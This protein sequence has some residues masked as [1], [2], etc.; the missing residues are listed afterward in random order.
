MSLR[1]RD[2]YKVEKW[3]MELCST[4]G[5]SPHQ[6]RAG[7]LFCER[8]RLNNRITELEDGIG[9]LESDRDDLQRQVADLEGDVRDL[10][11]ECDDL[12]NQV[13]NLGIERDQLED[14][15][16]SM[17]VD[18]DDNSYASQRVEEL[19]SELHQLEDELE[20]LRNER[21][22]EPAENDSPLAMEVSKLD[23]KLQSRQKQIERLR[24]QLGQRGQ[25]IDELETRLRAEQEHVKRLQ[26]H[27]AQLHRRDRTIVRRIIPIDDDIR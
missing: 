8:D 15:R 24:E 5:N 4:H 21:P 26:D 17:L 14:E 6:R 25:T 3:Y 11:D 20:G 23:R 22:D 9:S 13:T 16:D 10:K 1:Y 7:C 2:K 27:L 18:Y 12:S 19:E